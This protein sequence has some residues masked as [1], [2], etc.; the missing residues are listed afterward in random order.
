M[1]VSSTK[2]A[3]SNV[4]ESLCIVETSNFF[5]CANGD[6][7]TIFDIRKGMITPF[8]NSSIHT[9]PISSLA[10][11]PKYHTLFT[12]ALDGRVKMSSFDGN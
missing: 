2:N 4:V 6:K 9:K 8:H 3:L 1:P 5:A 12:A 10:Y 7:I 11:S